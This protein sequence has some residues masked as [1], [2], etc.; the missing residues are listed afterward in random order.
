MTKQTDFDRRLGEQ[1]AHAR[2]DMDMTQEE[3]GHLANLS[4]VAI[5]QIEAGKRKVSADEL[6][7]FS[8]A[9]QIPADYLVD[10]AK[11]PQ[12]VLE[13]GD[14]PA[15]PAARDSGLRISVPQQNVRKFKEVL[16]HLLTRVGGKPNVGETVLYKLLYFIDFDHYEKYEEQ[17]VGATYVKREYGPLPVEFQEI[18]REMTAANELQSCEADYFGKRQ[19]RYLALREPD[20]SILDGREIQTIEEVICRL[21][22]MNAVKIAEYSHKD[23]PWLAAEEGEVLDYESVF[24]RTAEYSVRPEVA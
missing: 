23:V 8:A 19:K 3:L 17:L 14:V 22:D 7:R 21:S 9:L 1:I 16:L 13:K 11:R 20:L 4:R 15:G 18:A 12:V 24:Y 10:P 5:G 6:Q 2:I